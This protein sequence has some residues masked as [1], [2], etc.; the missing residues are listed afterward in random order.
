MTRQAGETHS[1]L[2]FLHPAHGWLPADPTR[3]VVLETG[4]DYLKF[5]VGR[6]YSEVPPVSGSFVSSGSGSLD[7]TLAQVY[8]DRDTVSF[9]DALLLMETGPG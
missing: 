7:V 4:T 3:G 5:A 1:W 9:D 6:D 2:E 8:F